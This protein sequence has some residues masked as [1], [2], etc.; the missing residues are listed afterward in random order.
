MSKLTSWL[1]FGLP[2]VT[3]SAVV[4]VVTTGLTY[5]DAA[6]FPVSAA[7]NVPIEATS[8]PD[9]S[10]ADANAPSS[11]TMNGWRTTAASTTK[12][13]TGPGSPPPSP[14]PPPPPPIV[15]PGK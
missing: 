14:P 12:D 4:T 10:A 15:G 11:V 9:Q 8:T 13:D 6:E 7:W 5:T 2:A 1:A 3:T